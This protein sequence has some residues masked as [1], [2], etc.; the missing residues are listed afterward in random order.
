MK[1]IRKKTL[2][3]QQYF[4][5]IAISIMETFALFLISFW[6]GYLI[7]LYFNDPI[8]DPQKKRN[9]LPKIR[10]KNVE[11]LPYFRIHVKEKTYHIHHWLTLTLI[12]SFSI[13]GFEGIQHL[14]LLKAAAIGGIFQGLRYPTR[15]KFRYPRE[16]K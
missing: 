2:T 6:L 12:V 4:L 11:I 14:L 10:Y 8:K 1:E 5:T 3:L 13:V 9:R 16:K 7:F 15:F